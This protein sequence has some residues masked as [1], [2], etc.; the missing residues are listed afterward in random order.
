MSTPLDTYLE[1]AKITDDDFGAL[2]ERDRTMVSK[3]RRGKLLPT[4][5]VAGRIERVT[6]GEVPMQSWVREQAAA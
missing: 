5:E 6:N 1:R 3:L 2:I 4:L